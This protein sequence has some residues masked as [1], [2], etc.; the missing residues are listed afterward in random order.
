MN[1]FMH[2]MMLALCINTQPLSNKTTP[3]M[4]QTFVI[5]GIEVRLYL[6]LLQYGQQTRLTVVLHRQMDASVALLIRDVRI[7]ASL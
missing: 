5:L 1:T 3:H 7:A 6:G 2:V 4:T